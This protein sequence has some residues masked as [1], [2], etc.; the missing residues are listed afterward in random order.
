M[1]QLK[2]PEHRAAFLEYGDAWRQHF[3]NLLDRTGLVSSF[4]VERSRVRCDR[5]DA[6]LTFLSDTWNL[7]SAELYGESQ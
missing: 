7:T 1:I 4:C 2:R 6:R 5:A 3:E